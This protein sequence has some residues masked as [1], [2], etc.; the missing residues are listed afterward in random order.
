MRRSFPLLYLRRNQKVDPNQDSGCYCHLPSLHRHF[1]SPIKKPSHVETQGRPSVRIGYNTIKHVRFRK[2]DYLLPPGLGFRTRV[3]AN[4]RQAF[5]AFP[6][7]PSLDLSLD[8]THRNLCLARRCFSSLIM[9]GSREPL[10]HIRFDQMAAYPSRDRKLASRHRDFA[11][12]ST[13]YN[14]LVLL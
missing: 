6:N 5:D 4:C 8:P 11:T 12:E 14:P 7:M 10:N 1:D 2:L 3:E 13:N 9:H